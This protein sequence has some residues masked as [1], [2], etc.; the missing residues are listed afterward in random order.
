LIFVR[1]TGWMTLLARS[2]AAKDAELHSLDDAISL[3]SV[4]D[5]IREQMRQVRRQDQDAAAGW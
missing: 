3:A 5:R 2:A 4:M 1:M